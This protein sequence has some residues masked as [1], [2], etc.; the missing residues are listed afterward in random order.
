M[1]SRGGGQAQNAR[2]KN[3]FALAFV[4]VRHARGGPRGPRRQEGVHGMARRIKYVARLFLS[5]SAAVGIITA[6]R[7]YSRHDTV[8]AAWRSPAERARGGL[9]LSSAHGRIFVINTKMDHA[10]YSAD[11]WER[12]YPPSTFPQGV[13]YW[14]GP[15]RLI[16]Y[17]HDRFYQRLGFDAGSSESGNRP[18][19]HTSVRY[20]IVSWW[21]V[22][23]LVGAPPARAAARWLV[24]FPSERRRWRGLCVKCGYDL[25]A[26]ESG[27]C[28]ECG[29]PT[30]DTTRSG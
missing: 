23:L 9:Q 4:A 10:S 11:R 14:S 2:F 15:A 30:G 17:D 19:E 1:P 22:V 29:T 8:S 25:R 18:H 27:K 13:T 16:G 28:P 7:S 3:F 24:R 6:V 21:L 5:V 12:E 26:T 20:V